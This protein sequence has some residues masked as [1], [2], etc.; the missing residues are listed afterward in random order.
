MQWCLKSLIISRHQEEIHLKS[1][2]D[3]ALDRGCLG[4]LDGELA[5]LGD[6]VHVLLASA[7]PAHC[8][9]PQLRL[10]LL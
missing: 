10:L 2:L 7:G 1:V 3:L 5:L 9:R 8:R 6:H 4:V